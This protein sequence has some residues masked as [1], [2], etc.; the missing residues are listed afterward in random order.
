MDYREK[1]DAIFE[2]RHI[3]TGPSVWIAEFV[4]KLFKYSSKD[5]P[6]LE[7]AKT[8]INPLDSMDNDRGFLYDY[9]TTVLEQASQLAAL[10]KWTCISIRNGSILS[11]FRVV[12]EKCV[13]KHYNDGSLMVFSPIS[14]GELEDLVNESHCITFHNV[15]DLYEQCRQFII[16]RS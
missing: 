9:L 14:L 15:D 5:V 8:E 10:N 2:F 12:T 6:P 3:G 7:Q 4:I 16:D 1:L 11:L 13:E